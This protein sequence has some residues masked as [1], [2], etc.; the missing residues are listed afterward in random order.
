M[1]FDILVIGG[2][3]AGFFSALRAKSVDPSLK[4]GLL[5]KSAKL[6]TKVKISGGGRCNVTHHELDPKE[7][8]KNYPRGAKELLGPFY[9]FG[10]KETISWF[11]QR[12]VALKVESDRRMFPESNASST[13]IETFLQEAQ[14]LNVQIFCEKKIQSIEKK[15]DLFHIVFKDET[16]FQAKKLILST[17]SSRFGYEVATHFGHKLLQ[18]IPSLFTFN[19]QN[20]DLAE[21]SGIALQSVGCSLKAA[22]L[23]NV[24]PILITHFG[25]SGPVILKLSAF[26]AKHLYEKNYLDTVTINWVNCSEQQARDCLVD[27][28]Q[29]Q[30]EKTLQNVNPFNLPKKLWSHFLYRAALKGKKIKEVAD[31]KLLSFSEKLTSDAYKI[32]GKTTNKEEFVT[33][34]GVDLKEVNFKTM[35]SKLC[36]HLYFCGEILNIDGITGGFNFQ[37]AWTTGY[38]AGQAAASNYGQKP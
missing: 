20:F 7:L 32:H 17:G 19:I 31:K 2:G 24:G 3:A 34:G 12:G 10:P 6:L 38:L 35:E 23:K 36:Q 37:N 4:V 9:T 33:C 29:K 14:S 28:K 18:S 13:I 25:F 8:V 21:F 22:K 27:L 30:P 1:V 5:E 11:E 26:A 16:V 15:E